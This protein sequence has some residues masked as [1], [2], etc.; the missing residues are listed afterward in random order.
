MTLNDRSKR[1]LCAVVQSYIDSHA[2]VGSRFVTNKFVFNLSPATIRSIMADLED[3][4][5]LTQ[6]H[7]SAGRIPTDRGYRVYVDDLILQDAGND[8]RV[9]SFNSSA[10]KDFNSILT[11]VTSTL[12]QISHYLVFASSIR[13]DT[14][15]LNRIQLFKYKGRHIVALIVTD[16]GIIK[17]KLIE[18]DLGLSQ[19]ELN[20]I[21]DFLNS[22]FSGSTIDEI[23]QRLLKELSREKAIFDMIINK[24]LD[25]CAVA[26]DLPHDDLMIAGLSE[27]VGLPDFT[28]KVNEIVKTIEDKQRIIKM[29][30]ELSTGDAVK[31]LIG[32]E[33][34][35]C[36]LNGLS[37]I[38]APYKQSGRHVGNLG[39]IGPMRMDYS[40]TISLLKSAVESISKSMKQNGGQ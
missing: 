2:P 12:A 11:D 38:V 24:A 25:I 22:E 21:S 39:V 5:F 27:L 3:Q 15:T 10:S 26:L 6:P 8:Q 35:Y 16:E 29:L 31:V 37:V 7:I 9:S 19:R 1:I 36:E 17:N 34:P 30:D 20:R 40:K 13:P 18:S 4:G 14:T 28:N 33:N 32:S 23:R